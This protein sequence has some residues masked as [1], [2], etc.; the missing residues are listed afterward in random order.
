MAEIIPDKI[1]AG[2]TFDRLITLTE[3]Q[4]PEWNLTAHLRGPILIDLDAVADGTAHR[5]R[6]DAATTALWSPGTYTYSVRVS[7]GTDLAQIESGRVE[8]RPDIASLSAG[9]DSRDHVRKVLD[10]I[11]AVLEKRASIDQ[12]RYTINNRE[13][14]RTPIGDL[15]KLRDTYRAELRRMEAAKSGNLFGTVQ[16]RFT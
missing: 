13:L 10:A 1:D 6:A 15:L 4:P 16:V 3:Y 2:L 8:I 12:E 9:H 7:N 11:D 5:I 14:W